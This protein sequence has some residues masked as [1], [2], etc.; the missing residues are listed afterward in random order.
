MPA[1]TARTATTVNAETAEAA[2]NP[3]LGVLCELGVD[4][5]L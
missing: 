3:L 2:E 1:N 5:C 4:R